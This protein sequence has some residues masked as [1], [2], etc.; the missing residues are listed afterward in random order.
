MT[1]ES[2]RPDTDARRFA[3]RQ[4]DVQVMIGGPAPTVQTFPP[5]AVHPSARTGS[6]K[7]APRVRA[8]RL[9]AL[10]GFQQ[11]EGGVF[12]GRLFQILD[13]TTSGG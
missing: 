4:D 12:A 8:D 13:V 7:V 10:T 11:L 6:S 5:Q 3:S 9:S 1:E 2:S